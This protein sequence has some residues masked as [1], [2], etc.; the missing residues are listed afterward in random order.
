MPDV[1]TAKRL[2]KRLQDA[3]LIERLPGLGRCRSSA[4]CDE[5]VIDRQG[6]VDPWFGSATLGLG[7]GAPW[8]IEPKCAGRLS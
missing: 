8:A 1:Q 2:P 7:V 3:E 4:G 5:A 6:G